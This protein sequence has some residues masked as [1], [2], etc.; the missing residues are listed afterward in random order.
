[1]NKDII[2]IIQ[3]CD[4]LHNVRQD[5]SKPSSFF[6]FKDKKECKKMESMIRSKIQDLVN[7]EWTI[8]YLYSLQYAIKAYK[9]KLGYDRLKHIYI[10]EDIE[11]HPNDQSKFDT[12]YFDDIDKDTKIILDI[13]GDTITFT[14]F[15]NSTGNTFS[16]S[17]QL[18][19]QESQ[20]K[21]ESVCKERLV[22]LLES[23]CDF[24]CD[25]KR[26]E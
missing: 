16:V 20:K 14:I 25:I 8:S 18:R 11:D 6:K 5:L 7:E 10:S 26:K 15:D 17:S 12:M 3:S 21:I 4:L 22:E 13:I 1:M 2:M 24:C 23:Y 19:V 9:Q